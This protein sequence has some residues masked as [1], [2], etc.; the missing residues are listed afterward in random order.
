MRNDGAQNSLS[1][2]MEPRKVLLVCSG[3]CKE[4]ENCLQ[5]AGCRV[6]K[7][8]Q[9]RAAVNRARHEM[10]DTAVL[11]ST[12]PDMDLAETALN[13]R[14]I[15]PSIAIIFVADRQGGDQEADPTDAIAHAIPKAKV[16]TTIELGPYLD[17]PE[18]NVHPVPKPPR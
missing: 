11:I 2:Y 14:D 18:W 1:D 12:G 17:S 6:T 15:N 13:L 7:V 10:L 4:V 8:D 16:L 5:Q 9:G 3:I